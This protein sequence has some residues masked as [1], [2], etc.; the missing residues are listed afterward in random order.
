VALRLSATKDKPERHGEFVSFPPMMTWPKPS[1][2]P[3]PPIIVGGAFRL[4][5]RRAIRYG[6]GILPARRGTGSR[7][8]RG[9]RLPERQALENNAALRDQFVMWRTLLTGLAQ[10]SDQGDLLT[11]SSAPTSSPI[12]RFEALDMVELPVSVPD[13]CR[14]SIGASGWY[15]PT[16]G[17]GRSAYTEKRRRPQ[18]T[19]AL[20]RVSGDFLRGF[21]AAPAKP[22]QAEEGAP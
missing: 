3:H 1:Q 15:V 5:A 16:A 2:K 17:A 21:A 7:G 19:A 22:T 11:P 20:Q 13:E 9:G 6:D 12:L 18:R 14:F 8:N 4:A 10:S